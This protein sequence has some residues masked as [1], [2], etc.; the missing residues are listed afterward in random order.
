MKP[1]SA[2]SKVG[3]IDFSYTTNTEKENRGWVVDKVIASLVGE[4]VGYL[5][6][7]YI[8]KKNF[9]KFYPTIIEYLDF[10]GWCVGKKEDGLIEYVKNI[11]RH[12]DVDYLNKIYYDQN[13]SKY[14]EQ[15]ARE[16]LFSLKQELS[17]KY[18]KEFDAFKNQWVDKPLIDYID[19]EKKY[20]GTGIGYGLYIAGAKWMAERGLV[21]YASSVQSGEAERAWE[22][23]K[24]SGIPVKKDGKRT[25][26]D[27]RK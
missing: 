7:T 15:W 5:K 23:M 9:E 13:K 12:A 16:M 22:R 21:L 25:Y 27:Y 3:K 4:K 6:I 2:S 8:P 20:I 18:K 11:L 10:S 14:N 24:R 26:L 19:V 17:K 1:A